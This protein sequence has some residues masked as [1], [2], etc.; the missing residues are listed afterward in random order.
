MSHVTETAGQRL[1]RVRGS[2]GQDEFATRL[3]SHKNSIGRYE[4]DEREMDQS[5]LLKLKECFGISV[6]WLVSG[7]GEMFAAPQPESRENMISLEDM[8][9]VV[10]ELAAFLDREGIELEPE[11]WGQAAVVLYRMVARM[12]PQ[13]PTDRLAATTREII[14]DFRA[15]LKASG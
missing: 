4:R 8:R 11:G 1:K 13:I 2:L 15:F 10:Q 7:Q 5:F 14:G 6:D 3:G 9:V 12:R